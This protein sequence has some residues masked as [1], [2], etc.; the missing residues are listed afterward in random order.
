MHWTLDIVFREDE[1]RIR[2]G[3]GAQNFAILR[4]MALNLFKQD[5]ADKSS[6]NVK[7]LKAAWSTDYLA[8]LLGLPSS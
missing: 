1:C 6:M 5:K 3:H 8:A 4:R 2:T 7:R